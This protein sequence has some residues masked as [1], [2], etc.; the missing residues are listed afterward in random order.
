MVIFDGKK[1][2]DKILIGLKNEIDPWPKK[3]NLAVVSFGRKEE[4]SS[5][6]IQKRKT[7]EFLG[8]G[9]Q[10]YHYSNEAVSNEREYLNKIAGMEKNSAVVVQLPLAE[11]I[12]YSILNAIPAEKDPDL[13]SDKAVGLFFNG[14]SLVRPP[15]AAAILMIFDESGIPLRNKRVALFGYGR[16][17]GRF[18]APLLIKRGAVIAVLE[19]N[20]AREVVLDISSKADIIISAVGEPGLITADMV[21]DGAAVVDA[22]FS[23]VSG[24]IT[25]DVD[26]NSVK[27]KTSFI[28]PVPG[29]VGPVGVAELFANVIEL[30]KLSNKKQHR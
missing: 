30:F 11:G 10:H 20:V 14:R 16:L 6:I 4:N 9:F 19:K 25:G 3:P 13:L 26:F 12:N 2:A 22:G 18:L 29:G 21:K 1:L 24:K 7:A 23:I 15:T 5:Y 28:T 8:L 27:D 17:V